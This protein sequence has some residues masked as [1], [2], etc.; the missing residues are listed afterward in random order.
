MSRAFFFFPFHRESDSFRSFFFRQ[1][2][3]S[4][5][6]S[7]S[8]PDFFLRP[9]ADTILFGAPRG[10]DRH[11]FS[12]FRG[13]NGARA[14]TGDRDLFSP[15]KKGFLF[16]L[17]GSIEAVFFFV[18]PFSSSVVGGYFFFW[19]SPRA[20]LLSVPQLFPCR[21]RFFPFCFFFPRQHVSLLFSPGARHLFG[22]LSSRTFLFHVSWST[23]FSCRQ[24]RA[25]VDVPFF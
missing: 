8:F 12:I 23:A 21:A 17:M 11:L 18:S 9:W 7:P 10:N 19:S 25:C 2:R 4:I 22:I 16:A 5:V 14:E 3:R 24:A 15:P 1:P 6:S 20:H 13:L